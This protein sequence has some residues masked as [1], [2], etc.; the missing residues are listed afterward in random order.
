[1]KDKSD[2]LALCAMPKF[3]TNWKRW[4][5]LIGGAGTKGQAQPTQECV[6]R[7]RQDCKGASRCREFPEKEG[8]GELIYV[9]LPK[10]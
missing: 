7:A 4:K 9:K 1:M 10:V 8:A 6:G 3:A 5:D 2:H